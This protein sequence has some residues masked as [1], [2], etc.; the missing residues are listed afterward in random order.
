[1]A[2]LLNSSHLSQQDVTFDGDSI[3]I[4]SPGGAVSISD[5][6]DVRSVFSVTSIP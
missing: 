5:F 4:R 1:M 2:S 6:E 3:V